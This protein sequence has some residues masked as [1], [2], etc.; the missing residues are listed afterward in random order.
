MWIKYKHSYQENLGDSI[1]LVVVGANMGRGKWAGVYGA[2]FGAI[3]DK[4]TDSF[5]TTC[6]IASGF[7]EDVLKTLM[8][9]FDP[10]RI[11]KQDPRVELPKEIKPDVLFSPNIVIEVRGDEI[12]LSPTYS[13][14]FGEFK[15]NAGLSIRFPRFIQ[16][17]KDKN[18]ED[19]TTTDELIQM[20]QN[21]NKK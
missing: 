11:K 14:A 9:L 5:K 4:D 12:T 16:I 20:F 18:P 3:Y 13:A 10:L 8:D 7:T 21:Q 2:V 15:E 1:D 6:K 17:R 19:A